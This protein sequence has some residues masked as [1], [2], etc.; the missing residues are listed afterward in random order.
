MNLPPTI[1]IKCQLVLVMEE[2][3]CSVCLCFS[4]SIH[5]LIC[6]HHIP[7]STIS[8]PVWVT[9]LKSS[10]GAGHRLR[11][12][13]STLTLPQEHLPL[14]PHWIVVG[15]PRQWFIKLLLWKQFWQSYLQLACI[16]TDQSSNAVLHLVL[17][18][19][20]LGF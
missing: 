16:P 14:F 6:I 8:S 15:V 9:L 7:P 12:D 17:Q 10:T 20:H 3:D 18:K 13:L 11:T 19:S 1:V 2:R 4:H 5:D